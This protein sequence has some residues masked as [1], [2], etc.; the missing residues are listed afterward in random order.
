[1]VGEVVA[2]TLRWDLWDVGRLKMGGRVWK[3]SIP[4]LESPTWGATTYRRTFK[5]M[6]WGSLT[7]SWEA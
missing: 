4:C 6:E 1:M 3:V 7:G 2:M 5:E